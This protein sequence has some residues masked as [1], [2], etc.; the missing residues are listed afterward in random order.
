MLHALYRHGGDSFSYGKREECRRARLACRGGP[1]GRVAARLQQEAR[2]IVAYDVTQFRGMIEEALTHV[3][4]D[5]ATP[6]AINLLLG[7]AAQES[8]FGKYFKQKA[9]PAVGAFQMEPNTFE[10]LKARYG[11]KYPQIQGRG[12]P[13]MKWDLRLAILMARLRY[14]VY[15]VPL[16]PENDIEAIADY[17]KVAYN[18]KLGKG[19]KEQF[20]ENYRRYVDAAV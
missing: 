11:D 4:P 17:W 1:V 7:T 9:G 13:E 14:L 2:D 15:P 6:A 8:G 16:P 3:D 19:T 12:A 5:L 18:T 10:W 20:V